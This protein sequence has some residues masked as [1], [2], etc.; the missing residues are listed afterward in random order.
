MSTHL[1]RHRA[2]K[3]AKQEFAKRLLAIPA[4]K[5]HVQPSDGGFSP[6]EL[7]EHLAKAEEFNL[8]FLRKV[9]PQQIASRRVK[10]GPFYNMIL[11]SFTNLKRTSAPPMLKPA[12]TPDMDSHHSTWMKH[13][14]EV[15]SFITQVPSGS[16]PFIKMNFLFGTLSADQFLAF[17]EAH[18]KYHDHFFPQV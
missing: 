9:G 8:K 5:R 2:L 11:G 7:M 4:D 1:D 15:E 3:T 18:M 6:A 13:L 17:Q 12:K 14:E 16:S 10:P